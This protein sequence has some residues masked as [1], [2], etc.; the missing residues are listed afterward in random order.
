MSRILST[1]V[2]ALAAHPDRRFVWAEVS[3]FM[4]WWGDQ[5]AVVKE[6]VRKLVKNGQLEF[7]GGGWVQVREECIQRICCPR[8]RRLSRVVLLGHDCMV[9][10][11]C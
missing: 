1:T 7:V 6:S 9:V 5:P 3:F 2:E 11:W 4:R 10:G 8:R